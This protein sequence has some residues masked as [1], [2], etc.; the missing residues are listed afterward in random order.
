METSDFDTYPGDSVKLKPMQRDSQGLWPRFKFV[1]FILVNVII[2]L[3]GAA[4]SETAIGSL[5]HPHSLSGVLWK[6][7]ALSVGC[8]A[9]L[10]FAVRRVWKTSAANWTWILP[11]LWFLLRFIP[12]LIA[13]GDQSVLAHNV[14]TAYQFSGLGCANGMAL[15]CR[16][17]FVFTLPFLRAVA[18]SVA[19]GL[20]AWFDSHGSESTTSALEDV[21]AQAN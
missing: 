10:G 16:N 17:F 18:Y 6:E 11:S 1:L 14:G 20:S 8:A 19:A 4:I 15:E 13:T 21:R 9:F 3:L 7:Y 5:F 2:A 12:A